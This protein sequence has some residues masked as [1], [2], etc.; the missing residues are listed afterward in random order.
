MKGASKA[1]DLLL[2]ALNQKA[3]IADDRQKLQ[4][5]LMNGHSPQA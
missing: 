5:Y 3:E 1:H 2:I 4:N